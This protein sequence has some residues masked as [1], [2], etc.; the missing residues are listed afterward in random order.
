MTLFLYYILGGVGK[1]LYLCSPKRPFA[2]N[3]VCK[4]LNI[5]KIYIYI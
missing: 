3:W 4:M 1:C 5:N 2:R